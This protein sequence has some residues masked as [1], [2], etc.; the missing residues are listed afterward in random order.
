MDQCA[1]ASVL[2]V[3]SYRFLLRYSPLVTSHL[4]ATLRRAG[5]R[6]G[7]GGRCGRQAA[8]GRIMRGV[9][10]RR[11]AAADGTPPCRGTQAARRSCAGGGRGSGRRPVG[12]VECV[13]QRVGVADDVQREEPPMQLAGAQRQ[14]PR[15]VHAQ[16]APR[17]AGVGR[18]ELRAAR[19]G[20]R[21]QRE[22]LAR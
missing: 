5:G 20:G 1:R 3:S 18:L 8:G 2:G 6:G 19:R 17:L 13:G 4:V 9:A 15:V 7:E 21:A 12:E 16:A 11:G 14:C 10:E 22:G